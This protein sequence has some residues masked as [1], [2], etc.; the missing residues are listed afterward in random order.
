[1]ENG[2]NYQLFAS[3]KAV[4][5]I[6]SQLLER[7][8]PD[9]SLRLGVKGGGCAGFS[10]VLQYEDNNPSFKDIIFDIGGVR[11]VVDSKSILLLNGMTLDWQRSLVHQGFKFLNPNEKSSCGCGHSFTV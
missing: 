6:K 5:K 1:M 4:E 3:D 11:F 7:G 9:A 10:Y 8:T 2:K